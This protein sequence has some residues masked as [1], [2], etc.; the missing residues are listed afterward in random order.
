MNQWEVGSWLSLSNLV[1][2]L[3]KTKPVH[4]GEMPPKLTAII[5]LKLQGNTWMREVREERIFSSNVDKRGAENFTWNI[6]S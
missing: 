5:I 3:A 2:T 6:H 1:L 4:L